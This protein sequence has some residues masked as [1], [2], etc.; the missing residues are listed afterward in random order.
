MIHYFTYGLLNLSNACIVRCATVLLNLLPES[1]RYTIGN[2][3]CRKH[4][5]HWLFKSVWQAKAH[6]MQCTYKEHKNRS[7]NNWPEMP[8][9]H[10]WCISLKLKSSSCSLYKQW[11]RKGEQG[12]RTVDLFI[13]CNK[14]Q[15]NQWKRRKYS[16]IFWRGCFSLRSCRRAPCW[17]SGWTSSRPP[18]PWSDPS[19][20]FPSF[21]SRSVYLLLPRL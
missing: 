19:L 8:S 17:P 20:P 10:N 2:R 15:R 14:M 4:V 16:K 5:C 11:W 21:P 12:R 13:H 18:S 6:K 1:A 3:N 7:T 9:P